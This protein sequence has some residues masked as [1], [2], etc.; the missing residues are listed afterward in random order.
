MVAFASHDGCSTREDVPG[1]P[2][3]HRALHGHPLPDDPQYDV[4]ALVTDDSGGSDDSG[5]SGGFRD[6]GA[7]GGGEMLEWVRSAPYG[8]FFGLPA[9]DTDSDGDPSGGDATDSGN[10]TGTYDVRKDADLDGSISVSDISH[11]NSIASGGGYQTL[12]RDVL[13]STGVQNRTAY[14]GYRRDRDLG[15]LYH[16]R[17]RVLHTTLGRWLTRDPLGYVDG[18][19]LYGYLIANLLGATDPM[20]TIS[21]PF[22]QMWEDIGGMQSHTCGPDVTAWFLN[23][24]FWLHRALVRQRYHSWGLKRRIDFLRGYFCAGCPGDLKRLPFSTSCKTHDGTIIACPTN[25]CNFTI[26]LCDKCIPRDVLG[27]FFFGYIGRMFGIGL[28]VL[29]R[30]GGGLFDSDCDQQAILLGFDFYEGLCMWGMNDG[31]FGNARSIFCQMMSRY[32]SQC[33]RR[34]CR[35]CPCPGYR[36]KLI[37]RTGPIVPSE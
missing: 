9:G 15:T 24:M 13:S 29:R 27:N 2:P 10:I 17:H 33:G 37:G 22:F 18:E 7:S 25:P 23:R 19:N 35:S 30:G 11:A 31:T 14:A 32:S 34:D 20:G 6:S 3:E 21:D 12:G 1:G 16:V 8:G 26:M 4:T 36:E 28:D 5:A